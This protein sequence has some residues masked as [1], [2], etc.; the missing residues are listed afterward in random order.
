MVST[1]MW[2]DESALYQMDWEPS[3]RRESAKAYLRAR[4]TGL[5]PEN[6]NMAA[7]TEEESE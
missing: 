6:A 1:W 5:N 4:L 2:T 3:V 7:R